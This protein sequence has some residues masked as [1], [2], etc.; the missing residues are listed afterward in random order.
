VLSPDGVAD[1]P[2][3]FLTED[4]SLEEE[5]AIRKHVIRGTRPRTPKTPP[6]RIA[7]VLMPRTHGSRGRRNVRTRRAKAR[8]P[9]DDGSS[10][11][12]GEPEKSSG[13]SPSPEQLDALDLVALS[14]GWER[15]A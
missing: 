5:L 9:D 2:W 6:P 11:H 7:R 1:R 3:W 12:V 15:V 13:C 4:M 10:G 14:L 8:A